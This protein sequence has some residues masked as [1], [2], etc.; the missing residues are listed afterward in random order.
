MTAL[1]KGVDPDT[2]AATCR[3]SP[4]VHRRPAVRRLRDQDLRRHGRAATCR[5]ARRRCGPTTRSTSSSR[6][7]SAPT[8]SSRR[9]ATWASRRRSTAIRPR[10]SAA[11]RTA[12]RRWR[13]R[14]PTRRSPPAAT[15]LGRRRSRK[16]E[17]PGRARREGQARCRARFRVK[18]TRIFPD[19]VTAEATEILEQNIQAGTGDARARSAARRPARPGTTDNNTDAWFVGFT[20]RLATAVW[21][22]YPDR[23]VQMNGAVLR[24][25]RRRRHVPG[26][27]SGAST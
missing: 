13:W 14:R 8:R 10:R 9:R 6:S 26:R 23:D 18:R 19:G 20:P 21:V 12:S 1:R 17:L 27:R 11:S 5:C 3:K 22:G 25:P 4:T 2:H 24:R 15:A 7:T 16:I